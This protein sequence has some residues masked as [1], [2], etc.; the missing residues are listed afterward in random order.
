MRKIIQVQLI[1]L[2]LVGVVFPV[3][4]QRLINK[5]NTILQF[6]VSVSDDILS[7]LDSNEPRS[8]REKENLVKTKYLLDE[9]LIHKAFEIFESKLIDKSI[10]LKPV[11]IL[12]EQGINYNEYG[13]P[14][15]IPSK[16]IIKNLQKNGY[17]SDYFLSLDIIFNKVVDLFGSG[18]LIKQ[19]KLDTNVKCTLFDQAGRK[20]NISNGSTQ[21]ENLIR[22]KDFPEKKFDK[23]ELEYMELLVEKLIPELDE[24]MDIMLKDF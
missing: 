20:I 21:G 11:D 4:A 1:T 15:L 7:A 9:L 8:E 24:A 13:F 3:K 23:M 10:E 19:F 16:L 6:K 12:K 17:N 2:L 18:K 5:H 14:E 22:A